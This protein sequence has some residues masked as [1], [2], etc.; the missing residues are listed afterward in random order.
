MSTNEVREKKLF[1]R[2]EKLLELGNAYVI[3]QGGTGTL[4]EFAAVW[5]YANKN[6]QHPKPIICPS[7]MWKEIA[8]MMNKQFRLEKRR[9]NIVKCANSVDEIVEFLKNYC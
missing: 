7:Q 1:V 5:E 4:L 8:E 6:L 9:T 3:L 2:I